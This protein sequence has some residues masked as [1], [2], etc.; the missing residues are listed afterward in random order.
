MAYNSKPELYE[1]LVSKMTPDC[2]ADKHSS[3]DEAEWDDDM[4]PG[5]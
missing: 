4:A 5:T 2:R 3:C 1:R